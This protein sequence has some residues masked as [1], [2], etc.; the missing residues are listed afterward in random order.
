VAVWQDAVFGFSQTSIE[1]TDLLT[2]RILWRHKDKGWGSN[3]QL[4]LADG[5]I[6]GLTRGNELVLL[7]A[8]K[9]EYKERGRVKIDVGLGPQQP[10]L[11]NGR[12][13]VRAAEWV[14]CYD[15]AGSDLG[16]GATK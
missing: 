3:D 10:T 13:Y 2:G 12:L 8:D 7:E 6:F 11:A 15:V 1:C 5:L 14:I 9:S 16:K 4:M